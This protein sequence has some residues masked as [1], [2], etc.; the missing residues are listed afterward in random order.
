[1]SGKSERWATTKVTFVSRGGLE[2]EIWFIQFQTWGWRL[3][4]KRF[5]VASGTS[6]TKA[7]AFAEAKAA[8]R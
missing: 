1:M 7:L 4:D 2:I 3:T 6:R 8:S 5:P